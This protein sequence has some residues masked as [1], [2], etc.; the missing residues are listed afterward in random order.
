MDRLHIG[1]RSF[2]TTGLSKICK[3][4]YSPHHM[5]APALAW[6]FHLIITDAILCEKA[7]R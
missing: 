7:H 6:P 1:E 3:H 5:L 4:L 2:D